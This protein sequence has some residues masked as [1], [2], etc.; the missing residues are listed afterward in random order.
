MNHADRPIQRQATR[1]TVQSMRS[2]VSRR[3]RRPN[4]NANSTGAATAGAGAVG[5]PWSSRLSVESAA[6]LHAQYQLL[7]QQQQQ[8]GWSGVAG[9]RLDGSRASGERRRGCWGH[10]GDGGDGG[11]AGDTGRRA[12]DARRAAAGSSLRSLDMW[13]T[14]ARRRLTRKSVEAGAAAG[15]VAEGGEGGGGGWEARGA[16]V[17]AAESE[18]EFSATDSGSTGIER[19]SSSGSGSASGRSAWRLMVSRRRSSADD[20]VR[21]RRLSRT[22]AVSPRFYTLGHGASGGGRGGGSGSR[23]GSN[24]MRSN[25]PANFSATRMSTLQRQDTSKSRVML[26]YEKLA[27]QILSSAQLPEPEPSIATTQES[28]LPST[29]ASTRASGT[30]NRSGNVA[31]VPT[32]EQGQG[33]STTMER[34][35]GPPPAFACGAQLESQPPLPPESTLQYYWK[36]LKRFLY[37]RV[38]LP[39]AKRSA[40]VLSISQK[41]EGKEW[42]FQENGFEERSSFV[43]KWDFFISGKSFCLV[44]IALIWLIPANTAFSLGIFSVVFDIVI[45]A[46]FV[47]DSFIGFYTIRRVD[48]SEATTLREWQARYLARNLVLDVV[49][50]L[51]LSWI[52]RL[53]GTELA[54]FARLIRVV[55]LPAIALRNPFYVELRKVLERMMGLGQAFSG[56]FLLLFGLCVFLHVQACILFLSGRLM[57][58]SNG[59]IQAI[60]NQTQP[61]QYAWSLFQ[62][63]GNIVPIT[64]KPEEIIEE[65]VAVCFIIVGA[66]LNACIVGTISSIAMGMDASG[67]LYRQKMD[68]LRDYMD[69]KHLNPSLRRKIQKY[70]E[71]KYRGKLFEENALLDGI[72]SSLRTEVAV[73]N[74]KE[75]IKKVPFL[76]RQEDDGRDEQF[77]GRIALALTARYYVVGDT[78]VA[79]GET[80][81][82]MFFILSGMVNIVVNDRLVASFREGMFFGATVQAATSSILYCLT[83][84][85]FLGI[86]TEFEDVRVRVERIYHER[87]ERV[88]QEEEARKAK[89][90]EKDRAAAA[91]AAAASA[92]AGGAESP[93]SSFPSVSTTGTTTAD[94]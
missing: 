43:T 38:A 87:M 20:G 27:L 56:I 48:E 37:K 73:H 58:F 52:P 86:L 63:V 14:I 42:S 41:P 75:L 6:D 71:L 12:E 68:E 17:E 64:Y 76:N 44:Y 53:G 23:S 8:P 19:G 84:A 92:T 57:N 72:N 5:S 80:G 16:G 28:N 31:L 59:P 9:G 46:I 61:E 65:I 66:G 1:V 89:Q 62:A 7:Q 21:P 2:T 55:K 45:T 78:V 26:S 10:D 51:P 11:G 22:I 35:S 82:E 4:A 40:S 47:A 77:L 83:R 91:A 85:D 32:P 30:L 24:P 94:T 79:Q 50:V 88:L 39:D 3:R 15:V 54:D 29:K 67:R 60:I 18:D 93:S 70:Y 25:V 49:T 34:Q 36:R 74:C 69:W 90:M 81:A 13:R 33:S